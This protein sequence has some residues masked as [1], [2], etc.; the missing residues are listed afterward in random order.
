MYIIYVLDILFKIICMFV[1]ICWKI[2]VCK[3]ICELDC[4]V[5]VVK[6]E[7]GS[8]FFGGRLNRK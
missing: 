8:K 5:K 1:S 4:I 6:W 7:R 3:E 2:G